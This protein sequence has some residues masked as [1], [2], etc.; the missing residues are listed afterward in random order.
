[1]S[2]ARKAKETSK[3]KGSRAKARKAETRRS[4]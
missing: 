3:A 2:R 4:D 1:M